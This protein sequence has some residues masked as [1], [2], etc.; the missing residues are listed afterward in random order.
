MDIFNPTTIPTNLIKTIKTQVFIA[1]GTYTPS[2]GM[3]FCDIY[4][5]G[6]GGGGGGAKGDA[7][8][9]I[10]AS[11]GNSGSESQVLLT[12]AQIG[13]SQ[14]VT[15]GAGGTAGNATPSDGGVGGTTS[16]GTLC[17]ATGG[18]IGHQGIGNS[19]ALNSYNSSASTGDIVTTGNIG[20]PGSYSAN[21]TMN[22]VCTQGAASRFGS[23]GNTS[24]NTAGLV[25]NAGGVS[26]NLGC[27]GNGGGSGQAT[28]A[29][30]SAGS[31]G[32][33]YIREYC[34]I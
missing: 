13:A 31:S 16:V 17:V 3:A 26:A 4:A 25:A 14:V 6:G 8:H 1:S 34:T 11:G 2:A 9:T 15:I 10:I 20:Q 32:C 18:A 21:V 24:G 7:T 27:G 23:A 28:G 12:A 19:L 33:I 5:V 29:T 30:G 22:I